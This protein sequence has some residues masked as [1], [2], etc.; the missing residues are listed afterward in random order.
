MVKRTDSY[1]MIW[2]EATK[3]KLYTSTVTQTDKKY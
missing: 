3:N 1:D 2:D